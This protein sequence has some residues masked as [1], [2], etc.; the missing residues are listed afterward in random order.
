MT[1]FDSDLGRNAK[2]RLDP[3][4]RRAINRLPDYSDSELSFHQASYRWI[5]G[6]SSIQGTVASEI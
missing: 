5:Y 3:R 6:A 4:R 1:L 2:I